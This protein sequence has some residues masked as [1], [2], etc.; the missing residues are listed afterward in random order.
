MMQFHFYNVRNSKESS[1]VHAKSNSTLFLSAIFKRKST[2]VRD[3]E[4]VPG[5]P[6]MAKKG[7]MH[8]CWIPVFG[9]KLTMNFLPVNQI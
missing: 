2:F 4:N 3:Q 5:I 1:L 7:I 8:N 9:K 6:S